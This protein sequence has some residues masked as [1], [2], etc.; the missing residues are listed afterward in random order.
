MKIISDTFC[1]FPW[2][3]LHSWPNGKAMLCC[4]AN[5]GDNDGEVG[6]FSKNTF[7]EIINNEKLKQVRLDMLA[8]KKVAECSSCYNQE[9]FGMRSF[10]QATNEG[11]KNPLELLL[12][13]DESGFI[14]NPKMLYMDFRFSNL[15]NL[16]CRTCGHQLSSNI[17]NNHMSEASK[18]RDLPELIEKNVLSKQGTITSFVYARPDF[19]EK[20]VLPYIDDCRQFYFA[21]GE[22]LIHQEHYD[23]L[24]YL[25]ENKLYDK[26]ITYST[27]MTLLKWKKVNFLEKWKNFKQLQFM[28]SIDGHREMLEYIRDKS[29]HDVVF[30]NLEKLIKLKNDNPDNKFIVNICFTVSPYNIYYLGEFFDFLDENGF[31][32][33]NGL[34]SVQLN[35]AYGDEYNLANLPEFAKKELKEKIQFDGNRPSVIKALHSYS[36]TKSGWES[37]EERIDSKPDKP[38]DVFLKS[39]LFDYEKAKDAVPWL[40]SVVERYKII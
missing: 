27:N 14:E 1:A 19:F 12:G 17:A 7:A 28:C 40:A 38:F 13:T 11:F 6:D 26:F 4:V 9:K 33:A 15:C 30:S 5:G 21:G 29:K 36:V 10:R 39:S 32:E 24:N 8:G 3:H 20:D 2:M 22:P 37:I 16:G 18:Y 31:L 34:D 23:I 25:D 35:F